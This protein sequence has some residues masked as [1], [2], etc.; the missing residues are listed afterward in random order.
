MFVV[1]CT[2][3]ALSHPTVDG[4]F[5]ALVRS[6]SSPL[7]RGNPRWHSDDSEDTVFWSCCFTIVGDETV[8]SFLE[9]TVLERFVLSTFNKHFLDFCFLLLLSSRYHLIYSI[10]IIN[11]KIQL[12][13]QLKRSPARRKNGFLVI[14]YILVYI[15]IDSSVRVKRR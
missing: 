5:V 6:F 2:S 12:I 7:N 8:V 15:L 1:A 3:L 4:W 14:T 9:C 11:W 13:H 10:C